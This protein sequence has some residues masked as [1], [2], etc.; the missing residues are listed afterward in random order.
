MS[1][2]SER[3]Q[4]FERRLKKRSLTKQELSLQKLRSGKAKKARRPQKM[5]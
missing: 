1:Q 4:G 3:K 2:Q 5:G